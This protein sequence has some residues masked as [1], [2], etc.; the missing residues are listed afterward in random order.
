MK[1]N[2]NINKN[3]DLETCFM[4]LAKTLMSSRKNEKNPLQEQISIVT[5]ISIDSNSFSF[6]ISTSYQSLSS[7]SSHSYYFYKDLY[8]SFIYNHHQEHF[9]YISISSRNNIVISFPIIFEIGD[10][11]DKL[12][13]YF[14]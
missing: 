4:T 11:R 2:K 6:A 12:I 3:I 14:N 1:I 7:L 5:S 13:N 8:H 10:N 9:S